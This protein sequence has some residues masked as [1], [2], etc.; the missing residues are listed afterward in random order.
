MNLEEN[1]ENCLNGAFDMHVHPAPDVLDRSGDDIE[2]ARMANKAGM[3]GYLIKSH[4]VPTADRAFYVRKLLPDMK[5]YGTIS[6][7]NSV[8]GMN[9]LAVDIAGRSNAKLVWFPTV[10]SV[11]EFQ[12]RGKQDQS[13][14]PFW[15]KMQQELE[16]EHI[17]KTPV[18][19]FNDDGRVSRET[20]DVLD[21]IIKYKMILA[22]GHLSP[23]EG[24]ALVLH[25]RELGMEKIIITHADFPTTLYTIEDQKKLVRLGIFLERCYTTPATGKIPWDFVIKEVQETGPENNI[26]STDLGQKTSVLP[27]EGMRKFIKFFLDNGLSVDSIRKMT[28]ENPSKLL[29]E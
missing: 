3:A 7:N 21:R 1:I 5:V 24:M 25:A 14:L 12:M 23:K 26:L 6:L 11:N 4:Y 8:G 13:K 15:A 17:L 29:G 22:T 16:K 28:V 27:V 2:F 9:S 18:K 19:V 20:E 10:D